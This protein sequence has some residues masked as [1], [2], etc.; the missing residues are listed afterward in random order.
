[1]FTRNRLSLTVSLLFIVS[2]LAGPLS[3]ASGAL[4]VIS[5]AND[6]FA[7]ATSVRAGYY[8]QVD[9][10]YATMETGEPTC[11]GGIRSVWWKIDTPSTSP[12]TI[13][14]F[15]GNGYG[16]RLAVYTG[17]SLDD[18]S[19]I[20][21]KAAEGYTT[22][23]IDLTVASG[24]TYW[25]Q[26]TSAP[27]SRDGYL[28]L[29]VYDATPRLSGT[30]TDEAGAPLNGICVYAD[31]YSNWGYAYTDDDGHWAIKGL[32]PDAYRIEFYDCS[33]GEYIT[34]FYNDKTDYTLADPVQLTADSSVEG[35]DAQLAK[36]GWIE[37]TI[38]DENGNP[39]DTCVS[40]IK[41][42]TGGGPHAIKVGPRYSA[43][44]HGE[45][46]V[47]ISETGEY[48]VSFGCYGD[49]Y[50]QEYY[51]DKT[52]FD[53]ADRVS[54]TV[55]EVTQGI[56][57]ALALVP[58]P[59]NDNFANAAEIST[60]PSTV[61]LNVVNATQEMGEPAACGTTVYRSVWYKFTSTTDTVI[62]NSGA[63]DNI[64]MVFTG[65][66]F[67]DLKPVNC[68]NGRGAIEESAFE[69]S[70]GQTYYI[71]AGLRYDPQE[72][73]YFWFG[74][75]S[76]LRLTLEEGAGGSTASFD[77]PTP[78]AVACPYWQTPQSSSDD[79]ELACAPEPAS[80]AGS[81]ADKTVTVPD[82][83][84]GKTPKSLLFW[85]DPKLDFD[86]YVCRTQPAEWNHSYFVTSGANV[87]GDMCEVGP[88][89]CKEAVQVPVKPGETYVL[90]V[91][92]W[93]DTASSVAGGYSFTL[94]TASPTAI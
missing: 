85:I 90:R 34:E 70:A 89:G 12:M 59:A 64:S 51:N 6:D 39:I 65:S 41:A 17:T 81:W 24:S 52:D 27:D 22:S 75:P 94:S 28:Y 5:P 16:S 82:T 80:P 47:P 29:E 3:A 77:A 78:C 91:Y 48:I 43:D 42:P 93:S 14:L 45:Y 71:Q 63:W 88:F 72:P 76:T 46:R 10:Y 74:Y 69:A 18:L 87:V 57:A 55:G 67:Q 73:P 31:S 84:D 60:L 62:G 23:S 66:S 50:A 92:N 49:K 83:I 19:Q 56:N 11:Q 33:R 86:S 36:A 4:P 20:A 32:S 30:V 15:D 53:S 26:G 44:F 9:N 68:N 13:D 2:L 8:G 25:I 58:V 35:I 7:K 37:G 54:A 79:P 38:T 1:M 21:C 40:A 61:N